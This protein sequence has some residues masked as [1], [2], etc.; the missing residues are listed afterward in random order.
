[1]GGVRVRIR[2][3]FFSGHR[4]GILTGEWRKSLTAYRLGPSEV[5]HGFDTPHLGPVF[6]CKRGSGF[7]VI[8]VLVDRQGYPIYH[9]QTAVKEVLGFV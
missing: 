2:V 5:V 4:S 6:R 3:L 1:M 9:G 8:V 7:W